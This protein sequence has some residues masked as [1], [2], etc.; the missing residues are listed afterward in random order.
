MTNKQL[1]KREQEL[2]KTMQQWR[3]QQYQLL[4]KR[5]RG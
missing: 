1:T 4:L 3:V 2:Q 5:I